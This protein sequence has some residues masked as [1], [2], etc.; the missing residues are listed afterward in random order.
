MATDTVNFL[1]KMQ[2][3]LALEKSAKENCSDQFPGPVSSVATSWIQCSA[4][5]TPWGLSDALT[6]RPGC[7]PP[8]LA[9]PRSV[10][11]WPHDLSSPLAC[12]TKPS[13]GDTGPDPAPSQ[14]LPL[15]GSGI[16]A[17]PPSSAPGVLGGTASGLPVTSTSW[18]A[19]H[20]AVQAPRSAHASPAVPSAASNVV[21]TAGAAGVGHTY[22]P[23]ASII[24]DTVVTSAH[25]PGTASAA[26]GQGAP[27]KRCPSQLQSCERK[28]WLG[29]TMV[30][31]VCTSW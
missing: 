18:A 20:R 29:C 26:C 2:T 12:Y 4:D 25:R 13:E 9:A 15:A 17:A 21:E 27:S 10:G 3:P 19:S 5:N 31:F 23:A 7:V 1:V 8:A 24:G 16:A 6:S 30:R 11:H 14:P 22:S 28:L